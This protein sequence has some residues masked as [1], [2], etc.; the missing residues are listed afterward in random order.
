[1]QMM[2]L[3]HVHLQSR[4]FICHREPLLARLP[5]ESKNEVGP[6]VKRGSF[7]KFHRTQN[8]RVVMSAI[9]APQR[10]VINRFD[11]EFQR[12]ESPAADLVDHADL[13]FVH[14]I[15]T[16]PHGKAYNVRMIQGIRIEA[17]QVLGLCV[18]VGKRLEVDD[19]L[20]GM[21]TV[22]D[23]CNTIA[24]LIADRIGLYRGRWA[25][26]AVVAVGAASRRDGT[27]SIGTGETGVNDD[28]VDAL[29]ETF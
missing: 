26:G 27:V 13:L 18:G 21:K 12:D 5:W 17:T 4:H 29:S 1:M 7:D 11:S 22:S 14:A 10:V 6:D 19:E 28:L 9:D 8:S 3:H 25:E 24:D 16:R 2:D 15:C 23:V 20:V